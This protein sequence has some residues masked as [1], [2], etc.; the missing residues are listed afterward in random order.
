MLLS[1]QETEWALNQQ[2]EDLLERSFDRY[3]Y[4]DAIFYW[5]LIDYKC[6]LYGFNRFGYPIVQ[7]PNML[8]YIA[9]GR[10]ASAL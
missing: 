9:V 4:Y 6:R 2:Y 1:P 5:I 3:S 10:Y 7:P 8:W